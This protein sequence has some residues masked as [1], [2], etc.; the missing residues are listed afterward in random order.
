MP[1]LDINKTAAK[2]KAG[3]IT[4]S[5][6][7]WATKV[8]VTTPVATPTNNASVTKSTP[9]KTIPTKA[10]AVDTFWAVSWQSTLGQTVTPWARLSTGQTISKDTAKPVDLW[11]LNVWWDHAK[12]AESVAPWTIVKRNDAVVQNLLSQW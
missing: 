3:A 4:P 7:A 8:N 2:I 6:S 12:W 11:N 5:A 1:L 10:K 9:L